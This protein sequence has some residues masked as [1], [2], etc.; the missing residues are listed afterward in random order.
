[1]WVDTLWGW[2]EGGDD[3]ALVDH[4]AVGGHGWP[5]DRSTCR[6]ASTPDFGG[7]FEGNAGSWRGVGWFRC[8]VL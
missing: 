1:M 6:Q 8:L 5:G 7:R 2:V 4:I 3:L